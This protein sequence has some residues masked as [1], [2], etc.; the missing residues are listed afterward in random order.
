MDE[1]FRKSVSRVVNLLVRL[2]QIGFFILFTRYVFRRWWPARVSKLRNPDWCSGQRL[3]SEKHLFKLSDIV[4][5][6]ADNQFQ[7]LNF[8]L[9]HVI[10]PRIVLHIA[11]CF[12]I[13]LVSNVYRVLLSKF[14]HWEHGAQ[15]FALLWVGGLARAIHRSLLLRKVKYIRFRYS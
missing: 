4:L 2:Q 9:K 8:L 14:C 13:S 1:R 12:Q 10:L 15:V 7:V 5:L 3:V 11:L 6:L